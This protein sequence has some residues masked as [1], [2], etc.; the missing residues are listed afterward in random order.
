[1]LWLLTKKELKNN[2][3]SLRFILAL[4]VV[5]IIMLGSL[6]IRI[7]DYEHS[8]L[9]YQANKTGERQRFRHEHMWWWGFQREG[10]FLERPVQPLSVLVTGVERNADSRTR[11]FEMQRPLVRSVG[12][13]DRNPLLAI[14]SPVDLMFITGIVMSLLVLVLSFDSISGEREDGTLKL[15]LSFPVPRATLILAKWVGGMLTLFIPFV[16]SYLCV[17][18]WILLSRKI[19][20]ARQDWTAFCLIGVASLLYIGWMF[21]ASLM[22]S[23]WFRHAATSMCAL[24]FVWVAIVLVLPNMSP[25]IASSI[26]S[27]DSVQSV[28]FKSMKVSK[29]MI[30]DLMKEY[31]RIKK[32]NKSRGWWQ[33]DEGWQ[34]GLRLTSEMHDKLRRATQTIADAREAGVSKQTDL[35]RTIGR[36]SPFMSYSRIVTT[37]AWTGPEFGRHLLV[38]M[39]GQ[40]DLLRHITTEAM[41]Q[42]LPFG[43]ERI[44]Y[45]T[46]NP[47]PV[48]RRFVMTLMDWI[49]LITGAAVFFLAAYVSFVK[50]EIV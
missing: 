5:L 35:A 48:G 50:R 42:D 44:P 24:I 2:L 13:I 11:I 49:V 8:V 37:L 15:L 12:S 30:A 23:T 17:A 4:A 29:E 26:V 16:V 39:R 31:E 47:P 9:D 1:M 46:Y 18:I 45:F 32:E 20:F 25:Y 28:G 38:L 27:V 7:G 3:L 10:M 19:E 41:A 40:E 6:H 22:V 14:A 21:S 33:T 34:E 43:P 36:I